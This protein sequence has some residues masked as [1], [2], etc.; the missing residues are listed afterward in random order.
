VPGIIIGKNDHFAWSM[1]A[2]LNDNS[3]LYKESLMIGDDFYFID[4]S[5]YPYQTRDVIINVKGEKPV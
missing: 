3:D 1:T 5:Y 4:G 2:P